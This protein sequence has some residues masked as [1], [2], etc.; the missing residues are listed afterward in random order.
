MTKEL[1]EI[2]G[3]EE[4]ETPPTPPEETPKEETPAEPPQEKKN[5]DEV[6][7]EDIRRTL[8]AR[9]AAEEE[10]RKI[11]KIKK[12]AKKVVSGEEEDDEDDLPPID[13][14]DP[15]VKA[16]DKHIDNKVSP[17]NKEMEMEK[18]EV[19]GLALK[20]FL[21]DK[22]TL[23][24]DPEK[25]KRV[26]KNYHSLAQGE[27][28]ERNKEM[29]VN[30]LEKAYAAESHEELR[31][32]AHQERVNKAK[33]EG[34]FSDVAITK[35]LTGYPSSNPEQMPQFSDEERDIIKKMGYG[36]PEEY[37]KM[38]QKYPGEVETDDEKVRK[39]KEEK[40]SDN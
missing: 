6:Q 37:W 29:V 9:K 4:N 34:A 10:L 23:T 22:P 14:K 30:Y 19:R 31:D 12:T 21:A 24:K 36:S 1:D 40:T 2:L 27:I 15:S 25:L 17:V 16:W 26:M 18:D 33:A 8:E 35:G 38:K 28:T 3:E 5:E 7:E 20:D 11:R 32:K 13:Y 39:L